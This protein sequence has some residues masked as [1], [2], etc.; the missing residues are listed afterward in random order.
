MRAALG[1]A[2]AGLWLSMLAYVVRPAL[3][4]RTQLPLPRPLRYAGAALAHGC[5]PLV[6]AIFGALG[7]NVTRTVV[8]RE[9]HTLVTHG[10]YRFVRHPLYT[11]GTVAVAGLGLASASW[12]TAAHGIVA[13]ALLARR[14][15]QEE[16]AL[17]E[18]FGDDYRAYARRTGRFL[19]RPWATTC[20]HPPNGG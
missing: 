4:A 9:R 6:K 15:R 18:R 11:V 14:T 3:I 12:L 16:A 20:R 17:V 1:T 2:G 10:P 19:P 7:A 8:T 13:F 5:L